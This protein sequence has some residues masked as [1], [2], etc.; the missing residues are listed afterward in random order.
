MR[1]VT[2]ERLAGPDA[3]IG[4]G[5]APGETVITEGQ[6]RVIP[7]RP[8][9]IKTA[10]AAAGG[11]KSGKGAKGGKAPAKSGEPAAAKSGGKAP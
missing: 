8:V 6:L 4:K 9:E 2:V 3:V 1:P 11:E 10:G 5:L 7:G